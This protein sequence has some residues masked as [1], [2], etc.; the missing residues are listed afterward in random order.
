MKKY[1]LVTTNHL[2]NRLWF[3]DDEDFVTGM[4]YVAIQSFQSKVEILSF[5]LMSNHLH[6][7]IFGIYDEV[8]AFIN[9]LKCRYSHYYWNKYKVKELLRRNEIDILEVS[10]EEEA[11]EKVIAYVQVNCVKANICLYSAQYPWGTGNTFFNYDRRATRSLRDFSR[12]AR[13]RLLHSCCV[14][15]PLDWKICD[16]G[17]ILPESY[18]NVKLVES[19][20]RNPKRM[21]YFLSSSSKSHRR[22]MTSEKEHPVFRDQIVKSA[23]TDICVSLFRK[24][25][26]NELSEH[27]KVELMRQLRSRFCAGPNRGRLIIDAVYGVWWMQSMASAEFCLWRLLCLYRSILGTVASKKGGILQ[28]RCRFLDRCKR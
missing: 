16:A 18:V 1:Y 4:N 6:F 26:I 13:N 3:L 17:F 5:I 9:S 7:V 28:V 22:I 12:R 24:K 11:L 19:I 14:E 2:E 21:V 27:E 20:F 25:D 23:I 8:L 10:S 15:L